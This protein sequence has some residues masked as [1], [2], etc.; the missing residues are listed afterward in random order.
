MTDDRSAELPL[1]EAAF[2]RQF[3][4]AANPDVAQAGVNPWTHYVRWGNREGR[5]WSAAAKPV[6][7][8]VRRRPSL[9]LEVLARVPE[10]LQVALLT[11]GGV[12]ATLRA[13]VHPAFYEAQFERPDSVRDSTWSV[14]DVLE[15]YLT[16]GVDEGLRPSALFHEGWY[17]ESARRILDVDVEGP[18][19]LHWLA[20]GRPERISPTPLFDE[21]VYTTRHRDM[22]ALRGWSFEHFVAHGA[23]EGFRRASTVTRELVASP[24]ARADQRPLVL[25]LMLRDA[26]PEEA[27]TSTPLEELALLAARKRARLESPVMREMVDKAYRIEP[28]IR[29]PYGPREVSIPPL[30]NHASELARRGEAIRL[31]LGITTVDTVVLVPHVRMAGSARVAGVFS[32]ALREIE[33]DGVVLVLTTEAETFERPDWF[34]GDVLVADLSSHFEGLAEEVRTRL[35][36]DVVRGLK[37][38][39]VVNVNSRRGWEL[40]RLFGRQLSAVTDLYAYLFTWDLDQQGNKG[41]YPIAYFAECFGRL[42]GVLVDSASLRDELVD[43]YG[44]SAVLT[45]RI[46]LVHTPFEPEGELVD[47]TA[48]FASRRARGVRRRLIWCG[49]FDRQ[50]RFDVVVEL[51]RELPDDEIWVWGKTVLGGLDVDL[52]HLPENI[53]LQGVYRDFDDLPFES[54]DLFLYTAEWDGVPT[55]LIDAGIRGIAVVASEVGGVPDIINHS[56]GFPVAEFDDASAYVKVIEEMTGD[57]DGVTTRARALREHVRTSCSADAYRDGVRRALAIKSDRQ[58]EGATHD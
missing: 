49:R 13:M 25:D 31:E 56:T 54:A 24:T 6:E 23:Y 53:R 47:H 27:R 28:L 35:A 37:P 44:H 30:I 14:D 17:R 18:A 7:E 40:Y 8:V 45:R 46:N 41:G 9:V 51:A 11:D 22:A 39:R 26:T 55:V 4:L 48:V 32:R 19:F 36:L 38:R 12:W 42:A 34:G 33:P 5:L 21:V 1:L 43:R 10:D 52:A 29:R 3:Y 57:P 15:H 16:A 50:K 20:I 2:D 58:M